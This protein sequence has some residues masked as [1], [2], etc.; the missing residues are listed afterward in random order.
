MPMPSKLF[1]FMLWYAVA[2]GVAGVVAV[3]MVLA[4]YSVFPPPAP[5]T[6]ATPAPAPSVVPSLGQHIDVLEYNGCH[7]YVVGETLIINCA[8]TQDM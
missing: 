2:V 3:L 8:A 7:V 6:P 1:R 5:A 4:S